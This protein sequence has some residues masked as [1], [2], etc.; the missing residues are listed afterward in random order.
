MTTHKS[1]FEALVMADNCTFPRLNIRVNT[2][3]EDG[4]IRCK[5]SF[6]TKV[7]VKG[8]NGEKYFIPVM[9]SFSRIEEKDIMVCIKG[10]HSI[11]ENVRDHYITTEGHDVLAEDYKKVIEFKQ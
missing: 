1:N 9:D 10:V 11:C 6:F 3:E 4:G 7:L 5:L 2:Y 8:R